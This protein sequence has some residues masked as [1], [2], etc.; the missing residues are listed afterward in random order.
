M[1]ES[2]RVEGLPRLGTVDRT[3]SSR[4]AISI[5]GK[6][7][8]VLPISIDTGQGAPDHGNTEAMGWLG[9]IR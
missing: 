7:Y 5:Q 6:V 1:V 9:K 2:V 8:L 4:D 3:D